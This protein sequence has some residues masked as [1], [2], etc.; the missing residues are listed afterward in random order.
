M[1]HVVA[2]ADAVDKPR[3]DHEE[4]GREQELAPL[5]DQHGGGAMALAVS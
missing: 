1:V 3:L 4:G 2:G 5:A